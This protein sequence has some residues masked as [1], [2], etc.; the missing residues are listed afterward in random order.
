MEPAFEGGPEYGALSQ[1][2]GGV[3][4]LAGAKEGEEQSVLNLEGWRLARPPLY[5]GTH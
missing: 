4:Q 5:V 2:G 1:P 3:V